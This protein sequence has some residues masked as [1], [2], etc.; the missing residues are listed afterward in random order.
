MQPRQKPD[1]ARQGRAQQEP[2]VRRQ[3]G[4]LWHGETRT[5]RLAPNDE[6][7]ARL[8][9]D[10]AAMSEMFMMPPPSF[11]ELMAAIS[12][13]EGQAQRITRAQKSAS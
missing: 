8:A 10:Y 9:D 1:L 3:Q 4:I 11:D 13:L 6:L 12:A 5:L 7:R 2:D